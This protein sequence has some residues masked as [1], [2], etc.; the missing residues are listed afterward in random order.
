MKIRKK[1]MM[2]TLDGEVIVKSDGPLFYLFLV[3]KTYLFFVV[4]YATCIAS[5]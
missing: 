1:T 4:V 3:E 5:Q 2:Y